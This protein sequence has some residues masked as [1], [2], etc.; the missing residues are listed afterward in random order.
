MDQTPRP[1]DGGAE[2]EEAVSEWE[3]HKT[4]ARAFDAIAAGLVLG[5]ESEV[6]SP[7]QFIASLN[8]QSRML[9]R[10]AE[11]VLATHRT[12]ANSGPR[13]FAGADIQRMIS[14][15]RAD[16]IRYPRNPL[17]WIDF[18]LAYTSIGKPEKAKRCIDAALMLDPENRF[19]LRSAV[20]FF[21]HIGDGERARNVLDRARSTAR[22]PW[23]LAADLAAAAVCEKPSQ[24][25]KD[26]RSVLKSGKFSA[27][28]TSELAS[29]LGTLRYRDGRVREAKRLF[30]DA[31]SDPTE[32]SLAQIHWIASHDH[33]YQLAQ[34]HWHLANAFEVA[35]Y[36]AYSAGHWKTAV[37]ACTKWLQDEPFAARPAV[38]GSYIAATVLENYGENKRLAEEGLRANPNDH[39]LINN[40]AFALAQTGRTADATKCL[41]SINIA[42]LEPGDRIAKLATQG[43]ISFREGRP[44][45]GRALYHQAIDVA[46]APAY[47]QLKQMAMMYLAFQE[48]EAGTS[49]A[50]KAGTDALQK[51]VSATE[52]DVIYVRD[53][54]EA[55]VRRLIDAPRA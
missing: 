10:I 45:E 15:A 18:G 32:N 37:D 1:T 17:T 35:A 13:P 24:Y 9:A 26:A 20:R 4:V 12:D 36:E 30:A 3:R 33:S 38:L 34:T 8:N 6:L 46:A 16:L 43:L 27:H 14:E 22:D 55:R 39:Q 42:K 21:L 54:L 41:R 11:E 7:A 48:I 40:L 50:L 2:L 47:A 19:V 23:L 31:L 44:E 49:L 28:D 29:Q 53:R 52:P 25:L 5:C 51:V